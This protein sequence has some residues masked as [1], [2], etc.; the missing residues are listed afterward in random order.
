MLRLK[1]G[2]SLGMWEWATTSC[3]ACLLDIEE[4]AEVSKCG[5]CGAL[6]HADCFRNLLNTKSVCPKCRVSLYEQ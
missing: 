6:F 5:N 2:K 1:V 3:D 4:G